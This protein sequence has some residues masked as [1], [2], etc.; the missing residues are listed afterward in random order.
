MCCGAVPT[1]LKHMQQVGS[2]PRTHGRKG[3]GAADVLRPCASTLSDQCTGLLTYGPQSHKQFLL[4]QTTSCNEAGIWSAQVLLMRLRQVCIHPHLAMVYGG[5]SASGLPGPV[6][7]GTDPAAGVSTHQL[8]CSPEKQGWRCRRRSQIAF[9]A[10]P[11]PS[12]N[13]PSCTA[14][15][16]RSSGQDARARC[17]L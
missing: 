11:Q 3:C 16:R 8:L 7:D 4:R 14:D 1:A 12:C 2:A 13:V 9:A 10:Q 5:A 6:E 15:V 17:S